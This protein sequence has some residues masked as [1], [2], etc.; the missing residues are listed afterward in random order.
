MAG[1]TP[2]FQLNYFD[3]GTPG[4]PNDDGQK[5]F[6]LDRM[7][8]D[9][10]LAAVESHDHRFR[11]PALVPDGALVPTL[12]AGGGGLQGG[13]TYHYRYAVVDAQGNESIASPETVVVTPAL[14]PRPPAPSA[15]HD[16]EAA[17]GSLSA[18]LYYY[19]LT[20]I[21]GSEETPLGPTV[22]VQ[23]VGAEDSVTLDLP[24]FG[25]ADSVRVWRMGS[26]EPGY[27]KLGV[28]ASDVETFFDDGS[29]PADP[30][31][32]D[33]GNMPPSSN[34]GIS[35]YSVDLELPG[36]VD[37][38]DSQGWRLYRS[39]TPGVYPS[40]SL[41][42]FVVEREEEWDDDSPLLRTW[43]DI[44]GSLAS[45]KPLTTDVNM[46]FQPLAFDTVGELPDP[47]PYPSGYPIVA[48][49]TMYVR[50]DGQWEALAGGGGGG[51]MS[52]VFTSPSG[53][54]FILSV[55]DMG[56]LVTTPTDFPGPPPQP[57]SFGLDGG[58]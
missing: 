25:D 50:V 36:G 7:V 31:S 44:G 45:G 54:R 47:A 20:A 35:A 57:T 16:E 29:T 8:L 33:P 21:R 13:Y 3:A 49:G 11:P 27:T 4:T 39:M 52:S 32:C 37:L 58:E 18:G 46:R 51:G 48:D 10:L 5:F 43:T 15:Y 22:M 1:R 28:V 14:L 23:L 26:T 34:T 38:S 24:P 6:G 12:N 56:A 9:R 53:Y 19:A 17:A 41:V 2:R 55:D 40:A 42:H 30:C